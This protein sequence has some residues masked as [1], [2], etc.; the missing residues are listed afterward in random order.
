MR[1]AE[2]I[3]EIQK[4]SPNKTLASSTMTHLMLASPKSGLLL[5]RG[6]TLSLVDCVFDWSLNAECLEF[7]L[8]NHNVGSKIW[9]FDM[10]TMVQTGSNLLK[11]V[12]PKHQ[13]LKPWTGPSVQFRNFAELWTKLC[14]QF[15]SSS[16]SNHSSG[17]NM[18]TWS[19]YLAVLLDISWL[20][21]LP[22]QQANCISCI[23]Q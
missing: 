7:T 22:E 18:C 21:V 19:W 5:S 9:I 8:L 2:W 11:P 13:L 17:P 16:G 1:E 10:V 20:P 15:N 23:A 6:L 4:N 12:W 14:V 3:S